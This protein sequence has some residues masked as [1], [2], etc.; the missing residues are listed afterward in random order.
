M[1]EEAAEQVTEDAKIV[2]QALKR[3]HIFGGLTARL[4]SGPSRNLREREFFRKSEGVRIAV[5]ET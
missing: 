3:L 2:P 1:P 4:K 5:A